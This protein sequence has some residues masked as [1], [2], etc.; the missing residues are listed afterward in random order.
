MQEVNTPASLCNHV[1]DDGVCESGADGHAAAEN[2]VQC[3]QP[4][5]LEWSATLTKHNDGLS[6]IYVC[7]IAPWDGEDQHYRGDA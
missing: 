1:R 7:G 6:T 3:R 4:D 5:P 2:G